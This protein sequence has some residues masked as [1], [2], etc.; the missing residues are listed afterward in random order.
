MY[1]DRI[2]AGLILANELMKYKGEPGLVLAVPRGGVPIA[3]YVAVQL[4]FALDLL[5]TKKIGHPTNRE[6]AIGAVS[7]HDRYI[8][9]HQGVSQEYINMETEKIRE[10]LREMYIKFMDDKA[11]ADIQDKTVII[12]DDG[13]ATGNTLL[14]TIRM[15]KKAN[16]SKIII[17]VPVASKHAIDRLKELVDE[18]VCPLIPDSFY[19]VGAFYKN[20]D[21]VSDEE[22]MMYL[23]RFN[24]LKKVV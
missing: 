5:L 12:V 18:I 20:F 11:P 23:N 3:Y 21:Q 8:V 15:L 13:I 7:L 24:N 6:Y 16:P 10:K 2:D 22:V 19:G 9:H 1:Y 4:G 14:S 17:A